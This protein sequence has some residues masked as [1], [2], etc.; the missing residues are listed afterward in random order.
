MRFKLALAFFLSILF[1]QISHSER[2]NQKD[3]FG[4]TSPTMK[5]SMGQECDFILDSKT[6]INGK[7]I[8]VYGCV[9]NNVIK[10]IQPGDHCPA[11]IKI[12]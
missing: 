7:K 8:C 9:S 2:P 4:G 5:V 1:S 10:G 6:R 12:D 3:L 11:S